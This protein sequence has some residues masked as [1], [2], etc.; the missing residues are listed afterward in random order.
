MV[1]IR[2]QR[3][4]NKKKPFYRV[5]IAD[6]TKP[7]DGAFI[8]NVGTYNPLINTDQVKFHKDRI[9]YWLNVG[10]QPTRVVRDLLLKEKIL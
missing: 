7:R 2:L 3:Y 6:V 1:K 9:L 5:V 4:G 10:A 8:E